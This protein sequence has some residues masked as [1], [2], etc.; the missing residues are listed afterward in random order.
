MGRTVEGSGRDVCPLAVED[1]DEGLCKGEVA[2]PDEQSLLVGPRDEHVRRLRRS[3]WILFLLGL[4]RV[5]TRYRHRMP[6][7]GMR[8]RMYTACE[9]VPDPQVAPTTLL[10]SAS[11]SP[12]MI[13]CDAAPNLLLLD[14]GPLVSPDE[15]AHPCTSASPL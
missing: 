7:H 8:M 1:L 2:L 6:E 13:T 4:L 11:G 5:D 9:G 10:P 15:R 12:G 14:G 3:G